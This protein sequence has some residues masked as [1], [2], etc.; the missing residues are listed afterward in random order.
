MGS[1]VPAVPL[2]PL[3]ARPGWAGPALCAHG[4]DSPQPR[5][6]WAMAWV[7]ASQTGGAGPDGDRRAWQLGWGAGC[8]GSLVLLS[9]NRIHAEEAG[10][11]QELPPPLES[12]DTL[13][14]TC[15]RVTQGQTSQGERLGCGEAQAQLVLGKEVWAG[16]TACRDAI[17]TTP[18]W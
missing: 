6:G 13:A 5:C 11:S 17:Y 8:C 14:G 7:V 1:L 10:S 3:P 9:F 16:T 18:I 15:P 12:P 2:P 4:A